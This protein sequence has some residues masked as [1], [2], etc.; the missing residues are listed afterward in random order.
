MNLY[1]VIKIVDQQNIVQFIR[2]LTIYL[3]YI[4]YSSNFYIYILTSN[5]I[6]EQAKRILCIRYRRRNN[7]I[8]AVQIRTLTGQRLDKTNRQ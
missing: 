3:F 5:E 2:L 4:Q 6:R 7:R 1:R 8:I